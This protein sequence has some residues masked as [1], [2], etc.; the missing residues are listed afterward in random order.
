M[1]IAAKLNKK[2]STMRGKLFNDGKKSI[3]HWN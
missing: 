3:R 2:Y 1:Q